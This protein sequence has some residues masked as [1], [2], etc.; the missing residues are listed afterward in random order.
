[1]NS[2]TNPQKSIEEY[3]IALENAKV[4]NET[5]MIYIHF[6]KFLL[7]TNDYNGAIERR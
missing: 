4:I 2:S 3:N 1:M 5:R 6:A 7:S